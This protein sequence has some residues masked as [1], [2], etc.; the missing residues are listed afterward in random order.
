MTYVLKLFEY[1]DLHLWYS[2]LQMSEIYANITYI[3]HPKGLSKP[4]K[5]DVLF[6]KCPEHN[7]VVFVLEILMW[8]MFFVVVNQL[9]K[10]LMELLQKLSKANTWLLWHGGGTWRPSLDES[11]KAWEKASLK[12]K[13][14]CLHAVRIDAEEF[15]RF[16]FK[17]RNS[18]VTQ[19]GWAIAELINHW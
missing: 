7:S 4:I 18:A 11:F 17:L 6:K 5:K 19:Q 9:R 3:L 15:T 14:R 10:K 13:A 16:Y 12:K 1:L 8:D 2:V